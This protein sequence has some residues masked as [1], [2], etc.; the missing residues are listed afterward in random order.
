MNEQCCIPHQSVGRWQYDAFR[1]TA[2]TSKYHET[3]ERRDNERREHREQRVDDDTDAD[4]RFEAE[5]MRQY[6]TKYA[7]HRIAPDEALADQRHI[8]V[9][10]RCSLCI[11]CDRDSN[12]AVEE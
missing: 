7:R 1:C 11:R 3:D 4:D 10:P 12:D 5:A 2:Q 6:A 8:A 9:A